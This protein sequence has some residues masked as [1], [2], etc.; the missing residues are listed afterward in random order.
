MLIFC[1]YL[2]R[3]YSDAFSIIYYVMPNT[4]NIAE[5]WSFYCTNSNAS[6]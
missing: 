5:L 2:S 4:S 3:P 1:A 6:L